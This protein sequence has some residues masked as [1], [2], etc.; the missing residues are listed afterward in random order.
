[1]S[2]TRADYAQFMEH[3]SSPDSPVGIDVQFTHAI[4]IDYLQQILERL[5]RIEARL[6]A[7]ES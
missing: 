2:K 7:V 3:I 1:M 5:D 4:V 6:T